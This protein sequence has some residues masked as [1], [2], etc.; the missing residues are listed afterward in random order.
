M[1]KTAATY[2][3]QAALGNPKVSWSFDKA[4]GNSVAKFLFAEIRGINNEDNAN[5]IEVGDAVQLEIVFFNLKK[6]TTALDV[7]FH[8]IDELGHLVFVGSSSIHQPELKYFDTGEVR[9]ICHIPMNLLHEGN[10]NI[11]RLLLVQD[12]G[13]LNYEVRDV[14]QFEITAKRDE[15]FGWMGG[16]EG[17][18]KPKLEWIYKSII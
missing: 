5:V 1:Q 7:T 12:R 10:Y 6:G 13:I 16:K 18:V 15:D 11:G 14:L 9:F 2:L 8:L 4:P 17:I 3:K